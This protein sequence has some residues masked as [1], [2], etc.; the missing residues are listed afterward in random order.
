MDTNI[1]PTSSAV[2]MGCG[3]ACHLFEINIFED[4]PQVHLHFLTDAMDIGYEKVE[5]CCHGC[6][7]SVLLY[8]SDDAKPKANCRL[9]DN[10][11][12]LHR[13]CPN[14]K[15]ESWCPNYRSSFHRVDLRRGT[16]KG[17]RR[18][19]P[20]VLNLNCPSKNRKRASI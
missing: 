12:A 14:V 19:Q 10:F 20:K 7:T 17:F 8:Y 15:Y 6:G 11:L 9:R 16:P 13:D 1:A 5:I 3:H 4:A 18:T 2:V